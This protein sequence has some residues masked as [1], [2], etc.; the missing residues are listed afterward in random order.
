[1][2]VSVLLAAQE[3][4]TAYA[5]Q[6]TGAH[7][8]GEISILGLFIKGGYILIP[9]VL[10]SLVSVYLIVKKYLDFRKSLIIDPGMVEH[11]NNQL[12]NGDAK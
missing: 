2:N 1:M 8:T 4:G 11:F 12:R 9:I 10:L 3:T 6:M 5:M 7:E